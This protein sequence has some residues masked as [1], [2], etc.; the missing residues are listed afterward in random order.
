METL[1]AHRVVSC[2]EQFC[3]RTTRIQGPSCEACVD[4]PVR[5]AGGIALGV[6]AAMT[7]GLGL[8]VLGSGFGVWG[9]GFGVC[10]FGVRG[11]RCW[12]RGQGFGE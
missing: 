7:P 4:S 11:S 10:E 8:G 1:E 5:R 9:L 6:M 2:P 3:M 12:V